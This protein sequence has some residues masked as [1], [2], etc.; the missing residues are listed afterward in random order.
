MVDN[1]NDRSQ[2]SA[3][4]TLTK[5]EDTADLDQA[6]FYPIPRNQHFHIL[7]ELPSPALAV[8]SG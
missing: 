2:V 8:L 6:R 4:W 3:I 5:K 7:K 1:L